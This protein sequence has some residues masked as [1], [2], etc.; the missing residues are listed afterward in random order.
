MTLRDAVLALI[1]LT[2]PSIANAAGEP[3]PDALL[4]A[5]FDNWRADSSQTVMTMTVHRPDWEATQH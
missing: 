4:R 1:L 5:A 2:L 3:D